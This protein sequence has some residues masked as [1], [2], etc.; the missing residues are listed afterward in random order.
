M[1]R[2]V[3][4][5]AFDG[6]RLHRIKME[7]EDITR[8]ESERTRRIVIDSFG[9]EIDRPGEEIG[10]LRQDRRA[11]KSRTCAERQERSEE[12][13]DM[14]S[15]AARRIEGLD[16]GSNRHPERLQWLVNTGDERPD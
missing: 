10:F 2:S 11:R 13:E 6:G 7:R 1:P 4:E 8:S 9:F 3:D 16:E 15:F 14:E 5:D 12:R